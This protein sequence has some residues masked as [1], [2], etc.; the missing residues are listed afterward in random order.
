MVGALVAFAGTAIAPGIMAW[1]LL[2]LLRVR[3]PLI[4]VL[5][6]HYT[7]YLL[8][9]GLV[10]RFLHQSHLRCA[11]AVTLAMIA[12]GVIWLHL[13]GV[14]VS[15]N[16]RC[17]MWQTI[18]IPIIAIAAVLPSAYIYVHQGFFPGSGETFFAPGITDQLRNANLI[19]ALAENRQSVYFP[20]SD[21]IYQIA[22]HHAVANAT[23]LLPSPELSWLPRSLGASL[24]TGALC[25]ASILWVVVVLRGR[26]L[27]FFGLLFVSALALSDADIAGALWTLVKAGH[28]G[29]AAN[30]LTVL[31]TPYRY[32]SIALT[33]ITAP[34]HASFFI[35]C[36]LSAAL[37]YR[38]GLIGLSDS[39][40]T[41][42]I[43]GFI[44]TA[45]AGVINPIL[46]VLAAVPIGGAVLLL[47]V[48]ESRKIFLT[49]ICSAG[50]VVGAL[51]LHQLFLNFSIIELFTRPLVTESA[52]GPFGVDLFGEDGEFWTLRRLPALIPEALGCVG[53]VFGI[54][55]VMAAFTQPRRLLD[56]LPVAWILGLLTWN[57]IFVETE[58]QRH[59]SMVAVV[60]ALVGIGL[61]LPRTFVFLRWFNVGFVAVAGI[62]LFLHS[63]SVHS[64][65]HRGHSL[66]MVV[67]WPDYFCVGNLI[68]AKYPGLSV[69]TRT[70]DDLYLPIAA[71]FTTAMVWSQVAFVHQRVGDADA[72]I[73][74]RINSGNDQ[75][76]FKRNVLT[77]PQQTLDA[78]LRLGF[79]G[80]VWGP[81]EENSWG[82]KVREALTS[83][84]GFLGS[85]GRVSL[86]ALSGASVPTQQD[87]QTQLNEEKRFSERLHE[88]P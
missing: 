18:A 2:M 60:M 68:R 81:I 33:T 12:T 39:R 79:N 32:F 3:T 6:T 82:P 52:S 37:L 69:V 76:L 21:L 67:S 73:F 87:A 24:V 75:H 23:A 70:P 66:P 34:Q 88:L 59:F 51:V 30:G 35:V 46:F 49:F 72:A 1:L 57:L 86:Y 43:P 19:A 38:S 4:A 45:I 47:S 40:K 13:R 28:L 74:D 54:A 71:E 31:R 58:I 26:H 83:P 78:L 56:P 55:L 63:Y 27:S 20:N 16:Q 65:A 8:C 44:F 15:L 50:V 11:A 53:L 64:F 42:V 36:S 62:A 61:L 22:W 25:Y 29:I 10:F 9:A 7:I 41:A 77:R 48:G 5:A 80:L 14:A 85:C 17:D 84:A